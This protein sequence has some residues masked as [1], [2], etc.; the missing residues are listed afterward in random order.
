[1]TST[2][3]PSLGALLATAIAVLSAC[4]SNDDERRP[5]PDCIYPEAGR[6]SMP[7]PP[8]ETA[9]SGGT[10]T[11]GGTGGSNETGGVGGTAGSSGV[12]GTVP[13]AGGDLMLG[14]TGGDLGF[15]GTGAGVGI[16][17]ASATGGI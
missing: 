16:A 13:G 3:R 12:G 11:N 4:S 8:P 14:G 15:G 9:P 10:S 2:I 5:C 7:S 6:T 17:G 1:M